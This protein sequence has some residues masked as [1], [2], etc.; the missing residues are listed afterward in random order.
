MLRGDEPGTWPCCSV[1]ATG[2]VGAASFLGPPR[3]AQAAIGA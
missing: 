2:T 1:K 3:S